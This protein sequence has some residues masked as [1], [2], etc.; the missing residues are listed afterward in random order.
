MAMQTTTPV[1]SLII[2][3]KLIPARKR[4]AAVHIQ[5]GIHNQE[6]AIGIV[7]AGDKICPRVDAN[8]G[9]TVATDQLICFYTALIWV[10]WPTERVG[11]VVKITTGER[12][13]MTL[14]PSIC[15]TNCS[16]RNK[17]N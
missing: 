5:V 2:V 12:R 16:H 3:W 8:G 4:A 11:Y 7:D 6:G 10:A 17:D 14:A 9:L 1:R 15:S 13:T